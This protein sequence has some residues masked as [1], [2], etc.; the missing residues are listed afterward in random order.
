MTGYK[1]SGSREY[2]RAYVKRRKKEDA[3]F[4]TI[5]NIRKRLKDFIKGKTGIRSSVLVGC[6]HA[7][8]RDHIAMQFEP[9]MSWDNYGLWHVDHIKPLSSFDWESPNVKLMACHYSNLQPLWAANNLA[10][11]DKAAWVKAAP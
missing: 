6:S 7:Q 10:K 8:F 9:G 1:W 2:A 11:G 3:A 5:I 4:R